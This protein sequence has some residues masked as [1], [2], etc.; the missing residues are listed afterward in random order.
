LEPRTILCSRLI[1][2][3]LDLNCDMAKND[4]P[5]KQ[6][7]AGGLSTI[8]HQEQIFI[9]YLV[10]KAL[11]YAPKKSGGFLRGLPQAAGKGLFCARA[12]G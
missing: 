5:P 10:P 2:L 7:A 3:H 12:P 9:F 11:K 6:Q 8:F 4:N 1:L